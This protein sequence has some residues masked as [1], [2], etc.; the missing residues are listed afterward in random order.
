MEA[1][2]LKNR[3]NVIKEENNKQAIEKAKLEQSI[4]ISEAKL[5]EIKEEMSKNGVSPE[6]IE[7]VITQSTKTIDETL[8]KM[9]RALGIEQS[10]NL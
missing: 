9:E 4:D 2:E 1:R 3:L 5:K 6:T 8:S 7:D 10:F